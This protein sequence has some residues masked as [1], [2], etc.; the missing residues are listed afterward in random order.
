MT[1]QNTLPIIVGHQDTLLHL[2]LPERGAGRSFFVRSDK[3]HID[4]P[5]AREGGLAGGFFAI[6]V[7]EPCDDCDAKDRQ[8]VVIE[9]ENGYEIPYA[10]AVDPVYARGV[11]ITMMANLFRLEAESDGQVKVVRTVEELEYCLA[12]DIHAAILHMEG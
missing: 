10:R 9:T 5:R 8:M 11:T 1:S 2:Y 4:L 7:P 3:G 6:F 12:R